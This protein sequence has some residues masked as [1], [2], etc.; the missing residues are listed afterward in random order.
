M[1]ITGVGILG[2]RD[3]NG[4]RPLVL[5]SRK[6]LTREGARDYIFASESVAVDT[7]RFDLEGDVGAGEAVLVPCDGTGLV[8][9]LVCSDRARLTPCIF[10]FVY[11]A[12]PD[13]IMDGVQVG[14]THVRLKN[15]L[16]G[17]EIKGAGRRVRIG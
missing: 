11:F 14:H 15:M 9:R 8:H 13:S 7:L 3:P 12:R 17:L 16:Q 4:I 2:F 10:E 5:G 6:S 1:L